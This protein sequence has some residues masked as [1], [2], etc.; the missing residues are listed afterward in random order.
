MKEKLRR[1]ERAYYLPLVGP[2]RARAD[3]GVNA[4]ASLSAFTVLT[5]GLLKTEERKID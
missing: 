2:G 5:K 3:G 4:V 1:M